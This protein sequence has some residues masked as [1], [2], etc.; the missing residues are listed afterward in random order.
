MKKGSRVKPENDFKAAESRYS[1]AQKREGIMH[2]KFA[3]AALAATFVSAC[4][5]MGEAPAA[6]AAPSHPWAGV[7]GGSYTCTDGEHGFYL[8][9]ASLTPKDGGGFDATGVLGLF[10]T[11]AGQNGPVGKVAGSFAVSGTITADGTISMAP[12][13]WLVQPAGYGAAHLEGKIAPVASGHAITGK[14]VV[15]GNPAA[16][17]NLIATQFLP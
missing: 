8:D 1:P 11:L 5:T 9:I 13:D 10:P 6:P 17:S 15:P 7:Y 12:G 2:I 3:A 4:S 14:P 16:C